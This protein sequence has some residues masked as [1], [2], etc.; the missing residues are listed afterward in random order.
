MAITTTLAQQF[1]NF[2]RGVPPTVPAAVYVSLHTADPGDTGANEVTGGGYTRKAVVFDVPSGK[3]MTNSVA[4]EFEN[5]PTC[6]VTHAGLWDA[7]TG[8][9]FLWGD[10]LTE[11]KTVEAGNTLRFKAGAITITIS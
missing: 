2:L 4:V 10:V 8:G 9:N 7:E 6:T 11:P 3:T 5:L 1:L